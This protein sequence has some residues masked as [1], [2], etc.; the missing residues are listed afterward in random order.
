[1]ERRNRI[2]EIPNHRQLTCPHAIKLCRINF[3]VDDLG[4]RRESA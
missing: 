3:K 1:M 4:M 2:R